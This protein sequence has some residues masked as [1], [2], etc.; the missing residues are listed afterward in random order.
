MTWEMPCRQSPVEVLAEQKEKKEQSVDAFALV[1]ALLLDQW[2][3]YRVVGPDHYGWV[4]RRAKCIEGVVDCET[5][6]KVDF[7][8]CICL[9]PGAPGEV[10]QGWG[11]PCMKRDVFVQKVRDSVGNVMG[12]GRGRFFILV[13]QERQKESSRSSFERWGVEDEQSEGALFMLQVRGE[14]VCWTYDSLEESSRYG[15]GEE[16][17]GDEGWCFGGVLGCGLDRVSRPVSIEAEVGYRR[18]GKKYWLFLVIWEP[19]AR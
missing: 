14:E 9:G 15:G 2:D 17:W 3:H 12:T 13:H 11:S 8:L 6:E 1:G 5:L 7:E 16:C 4:R 19:L 18:R 10:D